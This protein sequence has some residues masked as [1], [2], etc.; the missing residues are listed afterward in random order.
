MQNHVYCNLIIIFYNL[1]YFMNTLQVLNMI[2]Y[3]TLYDHFVYKYHT[4][5]NIIFKNW[6]Q[7]IP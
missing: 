6:L 3:H 2:L 1:Y 7:S 5:K 4:I